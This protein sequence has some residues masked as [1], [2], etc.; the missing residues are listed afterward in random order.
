LTLLLVTFASFFVDRDRGAKVVVTHMESYVPISGELQ[1]QIFGTISGVINARKE[2]SV[3]A[4]LILIW[5]VLQVFTT[6][7]CAINRAWGAT[8]CNWWRL[9]LRSMLLFG[10]TA[11]TAVLGMSVP[12]LM[13][14]AKGFLLQ[15]HD[16]RPW[17]IGSATFLIPVFVLFFS[18]SFFY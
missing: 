7:I 17:M 16:I 9:P 3:V 2:A 1:R 18:L 6:L 15:G 14:V 10:I 5:P 4:I 8:V 12:V 13:R 11:G